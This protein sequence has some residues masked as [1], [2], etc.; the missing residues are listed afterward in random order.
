MGREG[1]EMFDV[2]KNLTVKHFMQSENMT[3]LKYYHI[4]WGVPEANVLDYDIIVSE[5]K[6]QSCYYVPFWNNTLGKGMN[7]LITP[8]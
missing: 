4:L 7:S 2:I 8:N 6:I 5:F 1:E 3:Y